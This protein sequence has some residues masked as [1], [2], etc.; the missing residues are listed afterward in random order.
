[1][2]DELDALCP[3]DK[4]NDLYPDRRVDC[5]EC[6]EALEA[7]WAAGPNPVEDAKAFLEALGEKKG[8]GE[9]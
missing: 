1:M 9:P 2:P 8:G 5:V 6:I 3:H 4:R 7:S